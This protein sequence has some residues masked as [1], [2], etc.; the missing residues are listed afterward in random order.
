[1]LKIRCMTNTDF[2]VQEKSG[3]SQIS[4]MP[5]SKRSETRFGLLDAV[6][7]L[8]FLAAFVALVY[9]LAK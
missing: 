8:G 9:L 2:I 7:A 5:S 3:V 1:M 6:L 4:L